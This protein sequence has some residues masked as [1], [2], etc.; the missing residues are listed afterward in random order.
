MTVPWYIFVHEITLVMGVPS[1]HLFSETVFI[2]TIY[3]YFRL[4][5]INETVSH[6]VMG[7]RVEADVAIL[8]SGQFR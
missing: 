6:V 2:M 3:L 1:S 7:E 8:E 4:S 5:H